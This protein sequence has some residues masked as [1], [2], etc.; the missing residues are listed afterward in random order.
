MAQKRVLASASFKTRQGLCDFIED[1]SIPQSD[2]QSIAVNN[3]YVLFYWVMK[4]QVDPDE[5]PQ[6]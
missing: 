1:F 3:E 6:P 4:D 2:V 5:E